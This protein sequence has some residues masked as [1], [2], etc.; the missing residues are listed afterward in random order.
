MYYL[1]WIPAPPV[2]PRDYCKL[3]F[4]GTEFSCIVHHS[5]NRKR[6]NPSGHFPDPLGPCRNPAAKAA[7]N[8][9]CPLSSSCRDSS[10]HT[11]ASCLP[12]CDI[13]LQVNNNRCHLPATRC[14]GGSVRS[15]SRG[16]MLAVPGGLLA[17]PRFPRGFVTVR[18]QNYLM[19][20]LC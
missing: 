12:A 15:S 19:F 20:R 8:P 1:V 2:N 5:N 11:P 4:F 7:K 16:L 17:G 14:V 10:K 3:S 9:G 18:G 6:R 13:S